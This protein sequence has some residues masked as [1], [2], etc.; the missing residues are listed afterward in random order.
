MV[1]QQQRSDRPWSTVSLVTSQM[2]VSP[3]LPP[4][5]LFHSNLTILYHLLRLLLST[6]YSSSVHHHHL[7]SHTNMTTRHQQRLSD[8]ALEVVERR[9]PNTVMNKNTIILLQQF[10][11][12]PSTPPICPHCSRAMVL[13]HNFRTSDNVEWACPTKPKQHCL[14]ARFGS[15]LGG[16]RKPMVI[17]GIIVLALTCSGVYAIL[18]RDPNRAPTFLDAMQWDEKLWPWYI[19]IHLPHFR[20]TACNHLWTHFILGF[21]TSGSV[22]YAW[23]CHQVY[24]RV[25]E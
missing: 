15:W 16:R 17:F 23:L 3:S 20:Y 14:S 24:P 11:I 9:D 18:P 2:A 8:N 4:V 12:L 21:V 5:I 13:R 25:M 6:P 19:A 22:L 1:V 7:K 10:G